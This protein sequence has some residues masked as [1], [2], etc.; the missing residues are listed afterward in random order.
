MSATV[1][2]TDT[3]VDYYTDDDGDY[4]TP[5]WVVFDVQLHRSCTKTI[6]RTYVYVCQ[7]SD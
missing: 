6:G 5:T 2:I 7:L 3:V 1:K 4:E